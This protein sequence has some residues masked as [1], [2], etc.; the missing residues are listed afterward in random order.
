METHKLTCPACG[1]SK[2][3][4][5]DTTL[6]LNGWDKGFRIAIG[7]ASF[8]VVKS[9]SFCHR[10]C[11]HAFQ[12][13]KRDTAFSI[14]NPKFFATLPPIV[15]AMY[16]Y[17][18]YSKLLLHTE[19]VPLVREL[20]SNGSSFQAIEDMHKVVQATAY[21]KAQKNYLLYMITNK[22]AV[23]NREI[24]PFPDYKHWPCQGIASKTIR[25]IYCEE[26]ERLEPVMVKH[27]QQMGGQYL[28]CDH[29]FWVAKYTCAADGKPIFSCLLTFMTEYGT[30]SGYWM[31]Q[32]KSMYD[33][34]SEVSQMKAHIN[35]L[36]F[37][38]KVIW[39]D[40]PASDTAFLK[41]IFGEDVQVKRDLFHVLQDYY[42]SCYSGG[43]QG[44]SVR[45]QFMEDVSNAFIT[46]DA[47]DKELVIQK[48][49]NP[50][51]LRSKGYSFW[52]KHKQV[53]KYLNKEPIQ[54]AQDLE[55]IHQLY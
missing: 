42:N 48:S 34:N 35:S 52:K 18:V 13:G 23:S 28:R 4:T 30:V 16:P 15:R 36:G 49:T 24:L 53:R 39:V 44:N 2:G 32:T 22:S 3:D 19:L 54:V 6:E 1:Q 14:L 51:E 29:T 46:I 7:T 43:V 5:E 8:S 27:M 9:R 20:K 41:S 11:P 45:E 10:N 31:A 55:T 25:N 38:V 21:A 33:L 12:N 50:E 17:L 37:S 40:N 47:G 26:V